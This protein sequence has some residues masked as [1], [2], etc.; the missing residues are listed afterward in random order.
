MSDARADWESRIGERS[1]VASVDVLPGLAAPTGLRA[2]AGRGQVTLDWSPVVGAVGYV[3]QRSQ[4]ATGP[5]EPIDTGRPDVMAIP[6]PPFAD[7]TGRPGREAW[8]GVSAIAAAGNGPGDPGAMGE[9]SEPAAATPLA[10]GDASVQLQVDATAVRGKLPRPWRPMVGSE[11]LSQLFYGAGPGGYEI[12]AEFGE[13]LRLAHRE[14]GVEAVRAHAILHDELGVY[15]EEDG[16]PIHDF[17][18]IDAV[19][20]ELLEIGLRPIVELG[21]MPHDLAREPQATVFDYRAIVSPPRDWERWSDLIRDLVAHLVARYGAD[22]VRGWAF[23][24]WN[25][26]NLSV[27]WSGSQAEY[28]RLYEVTARAVK[29]VDPRLRVGGPASAAA[30]WID[31]LLAHCAATGAP[32]DFLST[33][34]YGNV[35]LDLRPALERRGFAPDLPI[36]WTEWGVNA[37]HFNPLHDSAYAAAFLVAGVA[38]VMGR[39]DALSYWVVSDHFEELGRPPRLLHG[40]FGLLSVGNLRKPRWWALRML[41][42]LGDE[43]LAIEIDGDGARALVDAIATRHADGRVSILVWNATIDHAKAGGDPQL[44]RGVDLVVSGLPPGE[45]RL[46]HRRVDATH[47]NIGAVWAELANGRDWPDEATWAELRRR[48]VLDELEPPRTISV[49]DGD[50][51]LDLTLPMPSV[52]LLELARG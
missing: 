38:G 11:H 46:E 23:E 29:A 30:G 51:R 6:S 48:N 21:F 12:G 44:D 24:V 9:R 15:R 19:Y 17:T 40:G 43:R 45:W 47:S 18:Q 34:T 5:F 50:L 35:P 10:G 14:L 8:Y 4:S 52:S 32:L 22:E 26:A 16:R 39:L 1:E 31:E 49:D 3:V 13:A 28:L 27:F 20:D 36:W 41:E 33:H 2:T 37:A 42:S 25:E 7:T